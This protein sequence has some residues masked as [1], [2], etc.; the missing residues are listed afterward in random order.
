MY[1]FMK[2]TGFLLAGI[3]M[4]PA[5]GLKRFVI[6]PIIFN[7]LLF[8]SFFYCLYYF[9]YPYS[10]DLLELLPAWL[11]FLHVV[12]LAIYF[13]SCFLF[14]LSTFTV[15]C[16][17]LAAPFNGLLAEKAQ[18]MLYKEIIPELSFATIVVR[19]IKRQLQFIGYF[20]PR[21]LLMCL[22]FFIPVV[23]P[24]YPLLWFFFNA[25]ILSVQYQDF[26]MDNNLVSFEAMKNAIY[27]NKSQT[28][29]FGSL[30][31]LLSF[32]PVLN[33]IVMPAAVIGGVFMYHSQ[34]TQALA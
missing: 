31:N 10:A 19:S 22:L 23:H 18:Y 21:F 1:N 32:I 6:L 24:I 2:G 30:I 7:L 9:F 17:L 15:F 13:V 11:G 5:R 33:I 25:W 8:I 12:F 14:F 20:I 27:L 4:L 28:L 3:K 26:A 34:R 16:N 29:G